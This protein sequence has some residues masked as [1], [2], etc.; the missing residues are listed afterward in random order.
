MERVLES[1]K[2]N[3]H[4]TSTVKVYHAIWTKFNSFLI[5]LD[6]K[7]NTWEE[8][9]AM[10]CAY[11]VD[12]G[13]QSSTLKSYV[14]AIKA[15]LKG[16]GYLWDDGKLILGAII[17]GCRMKNDEIRIR[18]PIQIQLLEM[19]LFENRKTLQPS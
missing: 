6:R 17:R 12:A 18:L 19:L 5:R 10:Y 1:L 7:P 11:L 16:D 15:V 3:Q 13:I 9:V 14:S 4:R 2:C 8:R